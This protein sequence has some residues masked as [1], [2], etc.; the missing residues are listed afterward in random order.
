M[1]TILDV[2]RQHDVH[3]VTEG[4]K[5]TDGWIGIRCPFCRSSDYHLGLNLAKT[6]FH[7]WRCGSHR[8]VEVLEALCGVGR[9]EAIDLWRSV[10]PLGIP[11]PARDGA[12]QRRVSIHGYRRPTGVTALLPQHRRYLEGR[13]FDPDEIAEIGR[14]HV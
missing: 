4:T 7:C 3:Y 1:P 11:S 9:R 8:Q 5:V 10:A 6:Y 12:V 13:G 14:A 2:L